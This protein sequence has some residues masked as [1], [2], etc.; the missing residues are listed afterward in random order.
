MT[1]QV[2]ARPTVLSDRDWA[3]AVAI[4]LELTHESDIIRV[5]T[6]LKE[7]GLS[8]GRPPASQHRLQ[9]K[10]LYFAG[11][12]VIRSP[13]DETDVET[14]PFSFQH[15][16]A[17][18]FT[19]FATDGLNDCG[20]STILGILLWGLR[21][22]VPL[23]T[24]QADV[25]EDWLREVILTLE[26][27]NATLIVQ[28][29]VDRGRPDG[30]IYLATDDI[31]LS[32]LKDAGLAAATAEW[33][34]TSE[35]DVPTVWPGSD[36]VNDLH[37]TGLATVV[38]SFENQKM[39]ESAVAGVMMSR[40]DLEPVLVWQ[41][42]AGAADKHDASVSEHGWRTLST[43]MVITDPT[44]G[45]VI[46][47]E[48]FAVQH[49]M[50]VFLGSTWAPSRVT[51]RWQL[52]RADRDIAAVRRRAT[53]DQNVR[54]DTLDKLETELGARYSELEALGDVPDYN[55][56]L[57]ATETASRDAID[58]A[59]AQRSSLDAAAEYS[60]VERDLA[61]VSRDLHALVE[62]RAT[63]RFWHSL[64]PS[65]CP[66]CDRQIDQ[67]QWQREQEGHCSLCDAE[68][69]EVNEPM[70]ANH[71][72]MP[73]DQNNERDNLTD[74]EETEDELAAVE[75]QVAE[76][77]RQ[78]Y[79]ASIRASEAKA[80]LERARDTARASALALEQ[81]DRASAARRRQ[82]EDQVS[83]L[84]GR[85]AE[86]KVIEAA[87]DNPLLEE[88]IFAR[89]VFK[90]AGEYAE[91]ER[92]KE[93]RQTLER[94]SGVITDLGQKFGVRNLISAKL[95]ANGHLP[96]MKG[97]SSHKFSD[98]PGGERLRLRIAL[99]VGLLQS[100][101]QTGTGRHPG[102]LIVDDLTSQEINHDNAAAMVEELVK[103]QNLQVITASTYAQ[104]LKNAAGKLGDVVTPPPGHDVMF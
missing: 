75:S 31:D 51:A 29:L 101:T 73:E 57:A 28:W 91:K 30:A 79:E 46:G 54:R 9:V 87:L 102:L 14:V 92:D 20:K 74:G 99:I 94:V 72:S 24:L 8:A 93:H 96:V 97:V 77:T 42:R 68:F 63:R 32:P 66:R 61:E 83:V 35:A 37:S 76:L 39:F 16:F 58:V 4:A 103:I 86:R 62:A 12:K 100:G 13:G 25:R 52:S 47:E 22:V 53:D 69:V 38:A 90:A 18:Q 60:Q 67:E 82:I 45:S 64:R 89:Q 78:K 98:L 41:K 88:Q 7:A 84:R 17:S 80:A 44:S 15:S 2:P 65:C 71:V 5:E 81:Q 48:V 56:V 11:I 21:G 36:F 95:G 70:P 50:G 1:K 49:L 55:D 3:E 10:G 85:I 27:D 40:L 33:E 59:W 26:L 19:A 34:A 43:A 23:P 104:T 6:I